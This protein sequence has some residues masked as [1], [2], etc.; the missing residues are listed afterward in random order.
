[1]LKTHPTPLT[2]ARQTPR[3]LDCDGR[4]L[5]APVGAKPTKTTQPVNVQGGLRRSSPVSGYAAAHKSPVS[6]ERMSGELMRK[7]TDGAKPRL[8][9]GNLTSA[10]SS[11]GARAPFFAFCAA[12][13]ADSPLSLL[14]PRPVCALQSSPRAREMLVVGPDAR[15]LNVSDVALHLRFLQPHDTPCSIVPP[16]SSLPGPPPLQRQASICRPAGPLGRSCWTCKAARR[17]LCLPTPS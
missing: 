3:G 12:C 1:M 10:R 8:T 2:G 14:A 7:R 4:E 9:Q 15:A 16:S 11:S 13:L 17:E 5:V 6:M